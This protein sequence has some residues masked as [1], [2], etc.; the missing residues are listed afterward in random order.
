MKPSSDKPLPQELSKT[1]I[2]LWQKFLNIMD[3]WYH[4]ATRYHLIDVAEC[5]PM[6]D[7]LVRVAKADRDQAIVSAQLEL[8]LELKKSM[9]STSPFITEILQPKIDGYKAKLKRLTTQDSNSDLKKQVSR[10]TNGGKG[11][12]QDKT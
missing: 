3:N 11:H 6:I 4:A 5:K 2:E 12:S 7:Q 10:K 1:D 8:A 9:I